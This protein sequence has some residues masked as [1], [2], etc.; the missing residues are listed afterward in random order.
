MKHLLPSTSHIRAMAATAKLIKHLIKIQLE[1]GIFS[2]Q[3]QLELAI[4]SC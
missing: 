3:L 1:L 2:N 4:L